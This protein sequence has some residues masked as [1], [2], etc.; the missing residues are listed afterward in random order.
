M[1]APSANRL[2]GRRRA[3][4]GSQ[5][6]VVVLFPGVLQLLVALHLQRAG[7]GLAHAARQ[8]HLVDIAALGG[9]ERIGEARLT[10]VDALLECN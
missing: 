7:D 5:R 3:C 10:L 8:D 9:H 6:D 1:T 2:V 4:H